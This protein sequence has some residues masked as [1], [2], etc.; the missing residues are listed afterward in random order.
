MAIT[1]YY[2]HTDNRLGFDLE[3]VKD[4]INKNILNTSGMKNTLLISCPAFKDE[5]NNTFV[6]KSI[7]DYNIK[8]DG[9]NITSSMYDQDFFNRF[10]T[11]RSISD[12]FISYL[13]PTPIFVAE[14]ND[15]VMSQINAQFHDNDIVNKCIMIPGTFNIG[16]HLP[17]KI[18]LAIKFKQPGEIKIN[19]GDALFYVKFLTEEK[20]LFKKFIWSDE[21]ERLTIKNLEIRN[22]TR[23]IK[24]MQWWY[25]FMSQHNLKKYYL[26]RIKQHLI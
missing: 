23:S 7:Y 18:E 13:S 5:I 21:L 26:T 12:G 17:R 1:V 2:G 19:E 25:N 11:I 24:S 14:S 3:P 9:E 15:L 6:V 20:I 16:K 8:W 22:Y 10:L 4:Y